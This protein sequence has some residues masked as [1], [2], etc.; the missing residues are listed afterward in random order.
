MHNYICACFF[1]PPHQKKKHGVQGSFQQKKRNKKCFVSP[2][3][4]HG[5]PWRSTTTCVK[6]WL[7]RPLLINLFGFLTKH[8]GFQLLVVDVIGN[9]TPWK[10]KNKKFDKWEKNIVMNEDVYISDISYEKN[11][12]L[13]I[14]FSGEFLQFF[15]S[16]HGCFWKWWY[17]QIIQFNRDFHHKSSILGYHYFWKHPHGCDHPRNLLLVPSCAGMLRLL[18]RLGGKRS[19]RDVEGQ[20]VEIP[21]F[22][23]GFYTPQ[24]GQWWFGMSKPSTVWWYD[25][26][27]FLSIQT[28][29]TSEVSTLGICMPASLSANMYEITCERNC[30]TKHLDIFD[31]TTNGQKLRFMSM[32][33]MNPG[34]VSEYDMNHHI[35]HKIHRGSGATPKLSWEKLRSP[36][37]LREAPA[38][39]IWGLGWHP[40]WINELLVAR[41][42]VTLQLRFCR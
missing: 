24:V 8:P 33:S 9:K 26:W 14:V 19:L 37:W 6:D 23:S 34:D 20:V 4:H 11:L 38:A 18:P 36:S 13:F 40:K 21:V 27:T 35:F 25:S 7:I 1:G 16:P 10:K 3:W 29:K 17:P 5:L 31:D 2:A 28:A 12:D 22:T 32:N 42:K 39:F 41:C 15:W 30:Q